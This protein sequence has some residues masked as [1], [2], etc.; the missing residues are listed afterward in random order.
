[1]PCI[2]LLQHLL[3]GE[4]NPRKELIGHWN[5]AG[6]FDHG[7]FAMQIVYCRTKKSVQNNNIVN[8]WKQVD[9][10]QYERMIQ[11]IVFENVHAHEKNSF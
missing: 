4:K 8:N 10:R 5:S 9:W 2:I 1:M 6:Y 7:S 11:N 3:R